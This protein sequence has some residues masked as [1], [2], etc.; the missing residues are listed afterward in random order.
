M[1]FSY[2]DIVLKQRNVADEKKK[3]ND[4][5]AEYLP[6]SS[7]YPPVDCQMGHDVA[8]SCGAASSPHTQISITEK[9]KAKK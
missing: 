7:Q 5:I 2:G 8:S 9:S 3:T 4:T 1:S 6:L